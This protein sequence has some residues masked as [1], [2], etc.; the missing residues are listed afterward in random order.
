[1]VMYLKSSFSINS[2]DGCNIG[3][4][5]CILSSLEN[6]NSL[7]KIAEEKDIV[8]ELMDYKFYSP[9]IPITIN[10]ITDPFLN[11][12]VFDSTIEILKEIKKNNLKNPCVVITK[13][14]LSDVQAQILSDLKMNLICF[15]TLSGLSE[16]LENRDEKRQIETI[17]RLSKFKNIKLL[18]YYRPIIEGINSDEQTIRRIA[19][20]AIKYFQGSVIAGIRINSHLK[21]IFTELNIEIP[22][23]FDTEHK[24]ILNETYNRVINTF[25]Q[26]KP[27]YPCFKKTSCGLGFINNM[28]DYNG[29]S[30]RIDYCSP[31]CPSYNICFSSG[32]IGFCTEACPNYKNCKESSLT[33]VTKLDV[34]RLLKIIGK[35]NEFEIK[36]RVIYIQG[37]FTQEEITY[38]R[39]NLKRNIK[40]DKT[41]RCNNEDK[42]SK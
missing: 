22:F 3:C 26:L 13:G 36:E 2:Y 35:E 20:I 41:I 9:N 27:D 29:H 42:L 23:K 32:S 17:Q 30:G 40:V 24:V 16:K 19:N 31:S 33:P 37:E 15:Y 39:H 10:N 14:Y 18:H 38:L 8:K 12:K 5:Y 4:K 11:Q 21:K 7:K 25:K 28:A 1:M 34:E 6:R